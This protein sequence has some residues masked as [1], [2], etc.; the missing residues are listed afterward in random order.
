MI[1][2]GTSA[3]RNGVQV[4]DTIISVNGV[5]VDSM[6]LY[7]VSDLLNSEDARVVEVELIDGGKTRTVKLERRPLY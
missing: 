7:E 5:P 2:D 3:E 4:G 6:E 1:L